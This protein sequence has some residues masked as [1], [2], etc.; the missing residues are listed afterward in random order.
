MAYAV[1]SGV[2][3][4]SSPV[5]FWQFLKEELSPYPGRGALV[6][7]M[8][9]TA[10]IVM[11]ICMVFRIPYAAYAAL[12][13]VTLSRENSSET[14]KAAATVI[15][16]DALAAAY[17]LAGA[18]F[19]VGDPTLRLFWVIA[20]LFLTFYGLSA[21]TN[22]AAISRFGYLLIV[23]IPLWDRHVPASERVEGTLW[24]FAALSLASIITALG[25]LVYAEIAPRDDVLQSVNQRFSAVRE[26]LECYSVGRTVDSKTQTQITRLALAGGSA[27]RS[28]LQRSGYSPHHVEQMGA[29]VALAVRLLDIA[30]NLMNLSFEPS[31][32]DRARMHRAER[33]IAQ[34]QS[35]LLED[36][37]PSPIET[38][39]AQSSVPLLR[40]M[41]VTVSLIPDVFSGSQSTRAFAPEPALADPPSSFLVT[42]ALTN[43]KHIL[44]GLR[45]CLAASLCYVIYNAKDWPGI[46]TAITTCF[47]T[48]LT[49]IG[50]SHQKQILRITG[51]IIGSFVL[52]MGAQILILPYLDSIAGFTVLFLAV[53]ILA[54]WI[55]TS[56]PRLSYCGVQVLIAFY[57]IH[58]T[59]FR[60]QTSLEPARDRVV[61]IFLGLFM[62]W[63]AFDQ[64][65]ARP[66]VVEMK[67]TFIAT[68][69]CLAQF[70][71]E[72][73]SND[74]RAAA[75]RSYSLRETIGKN[76]DSV[77]GL[78]DAVALEF[79]PSRNQDLAFRRRIRE[80][81]PELRT[82]FLMRIALWKYR[83]QLPGFE[84][85]EPVRMAQQEFDYQLGEMLDNMADRLEEKAT[86]GKNGF[87]HSFEHLQETVWICCAEGMQNLLPARLHTFLALSGNVASLTMSLSKSA[88]VPGG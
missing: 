48:A 40:E 6:T 31:D 2:Q 17:V 77:R 58:L 67:Q 86:L 64:L 80:W 18:I 65:W 69:R 53:T 5:W 76:F 33:N 57:L 7:R 42:D 8:V 60:M 15:V 11:I 85:P 22:H 75:V 84:L 47:F 24:A 74:L 32:Q 19:F 59:E 4:L 10:T 50:A 66:A 21:L 35:A 29:V 63:L 83:V 62:M 52:G 45:G 3:P 30:A 78:A 27:L 81:Q 13:A 87:E 54:A 68:L 73:V 25:E 55:A 38:L 16:S 49:T 39:D 9:G 46:S 12:Y 82:L 61:G 71:R 43:P 20:T 26:L 88:T 28:N 34:I 23:T 56:G 79:G 44:F 41:E 72:P 14:L 36:R 70:A 1:P 37:I 51:A